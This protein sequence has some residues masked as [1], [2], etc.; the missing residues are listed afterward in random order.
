MKY[1]GNSLNIVDKIKYL[2]TDVVVV[3]VAAVILLILNFYS[4]I[5]WINKPLNLH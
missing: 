5:E 1:D 3:I 2:A 4:E